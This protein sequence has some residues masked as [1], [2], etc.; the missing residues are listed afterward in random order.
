VGRI[1]LRDL[2]NISDKDRKQ[3]QQTEE[4]LGPDPA[5]IGFIKNLFWGNFRQELVLPYPEVDPS[6]VKR[7]DRLLE[8]LDGY[9]RYEHPDIEIDQK[10][11]IPDWVVERLFGM[12]VLGMI[13]PQ[14]F[15]GGGFS[16]TSYNRVLER[17]GRTCGSTAVLVSAHQSI[18]CG[19]LVLFGSEEQKQRFLPRMATDTLSAFCLSEPNVGSDAA[20]QE[21]WCELSE[22]GRHYIL[23]GEKKWATSAALSGLFTVMAKQ[24]LRDPD[25]AQP[26]E[27]VTA[28]I[29]TPDM[30]G[31]EIFSRNRS[32]C[33]IR[34]TWQ[35][36]IRFT[37]VKVPRAN[38]LHKEGKGL[39][40]AL[41]CLNIGRCTLSAGMVGAARTAYHQGLKWARYRYQFDRPIAEFEQMQ[42]KLAAMAAY[43]Y[44]MEAMLYLTT[45]IVDRNDEDIMLETAACKV[46]C[47]EMGFRTV[48][49][50]LQ[51]MGG[52][53]YM[54]ENVVER[55]WRDSRINLI[56]EGANE[57]MHSFI[58]GYGSKQLGEH[59]LE[60]R[61]RPFSDLRAAWQT[62]S[63][64]YLG[65]R[66]KPPE[67]T[68]LHPRLDEM[69]LSLQ[70]RVRDFSHEVKLALKRHE[71]RLIWK[72]MM[73]YRMSTCAIWIHAMA[74]S[75]SRLDAALR[76]GT[77]DASEIEIVEHLCALAAEEISGATQAL[78]ENTDASMRRA[79]GAAMKL[80]EALPNSDYVIPERTPV[81]SARGTGRI[82]NQDAIPQFGAGTA[83]DPEKSV[84]P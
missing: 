17:I 21:T 11:Y 50:A 13:I 52:E 2:K 31:V 14:Q 55:L 19:A 60:L 30:E 27:R 73:H 16:I 51:I 43:I 32:K 58:F 5:S 62:A 24:K 48:D 72:Q 29:C 15:G 53:G 23:N 66:R 65:M 75:L 3:L 42:E 80:E 40:V 6:E 9:L 63:E 1:D 56:V 46:F 33:G 25:S 69:R 37:N 84:T 45:G 18:G 76:R 57:V 81:D 35:A 22:D 79:A 67:I 7:C 74:C 61:N 28:L 36:R 10:Q 59:L 20:G 54:T 26:V 8:Q 78:R 83:F 77:A 4:M 64:L 12:G 39:N 68:R 49:H 41:T 70:R 34:G 71:E 82:S 44:A 38:L 47:S